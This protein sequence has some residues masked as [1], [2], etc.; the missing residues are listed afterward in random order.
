M[1]KKLLFVIILL[2][3]T[4]QLSYSKNAKGDGTVN[5]ELVFHSTENNFYNNG[6]EINIELIAAKN[7]FEYAEVISL[8]NGKKRKTPLNYGGD[9]GEK[10][11][12]MGKVPLYN[13]K[14][15]YYFMIKD[16]RKK[17]YFGKTG[18]KKE[19]STVKFSYDKPAVKDYS[20]TEWIKSGIA[21]EIVIDRFRNGDKKNDPLYNEISGYLINPVTK[22]I[23]GSL[24]YQ[25]AGID[26]KP[27]GG[28]DEFSVSEWGGNWRKS[29]KWETKLNTVSQETRRYGGDI[30][31]IVEKIE[32]LK[33]LGVKS[34]ILSAPFY[35]SDAMKTAV[36]DFMHVDPSFGVIVDGNGGKSEYKIIDYDINTVTNGAGEKIKGESKLYFTESDQ[37]FSEMIKKL[38]QNGIRVIIKMPSDYTSVN[39]P[40][41][42]KAIKEGPNS[43]YANW[44][45]F[46][47]W[48]N[49]TRSE[50]DSSVWNPLVEYSGNEKAGVVIKEGRKY[51][52]RWVA[53]S[54]EMSENE[55]NEL[56]R[57]NIK[58][59][60]YSMLGNSYNYPKLNF[61]NNNVY[62]YYENSLLKWVKGYDGK[63][64]DK[65]EEDDGIDGV[66][67]CNYEDATNKSE[68]NNISENIKSIKKEFY[69]GSDLGL[70][71]KK[72]LHSSVI[73]GVLNY[74][75]ILNGMKLLINRSKEMLKGEEFAL[76]IE[77]LYF[78]L[79]DGIARESFNS[80]GGSDSDRVY[81][82]VINPDRDYDRENDGKS[83]KYR[84]I[85]PEFY[86][87][88]AIRD[89]KNM[90][91]LQFSLPGMPLIYYGDEKGMWGADTPENMKPMLWEDMTY[92]MESDLISKYKSDDS[93]MKSTKIEIDE[94]NGRIFYKVEANEDIVK[95]YK[96][97]IKARVDNQELFTN[98]E[99]KFAVKEQDKNCLAYEIKDNKRGALVL[100]NLSDK[101]NSVK[102]P[103]ENS[104]DFYNVDDGERYSVIDKVMEVKLK[105]KEGVLLIKK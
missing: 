66:I 57:W 3:I 82:M 97:I 95:F 14:A 53:E 73:N 23:G 58:N 71:S 16:G 4:V 39:F 24:N 105:A 68:L 51:R 76:E 64:S 55:K 19:K 93:V 59:T 22:R 10:S 20:S 67:F 21:Y 75:V 7:D 49:I 26:V 74:G 88:N 45:N 102:V 27:Q 86:S 96:S 65:I 15:E 2:F 77:K 25:D 91:I 46:E 81:S 28:L 30:S 37:I 31:G 47:E 79:S 9:I 43:E 103:M 29:E 56:F 41:F 101:E 69:V 80:T 90:V 52:K 72:E 62:E 34:I 40:A 1:K 50:G 94:A 11:R 33:E 44:Y 35:G 85:R 48:K 38:H 60:K 63:I 36:N 87:V 54:S 6:K 99:F 92:A 13:G 98:G 17:F 18:I 32:Y 78:N 100:F 42:R 84:S 89:L 8:E 12:Y 70:I 61:K 5:G 83:E 104:G